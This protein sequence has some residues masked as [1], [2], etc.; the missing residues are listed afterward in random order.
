MLK[1]SY[2]QL[3]YRRD[4]ESSPRRD[5]KC[6]I[7]AIFGRYIWKAIS[8]DASKR[9]RPNLDRELR[10]FRTIDLRPRPLPVIYT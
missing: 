7:I 5:V 4:R 2:R 1:K 9:G 3:L 8:P 6:A 10:R